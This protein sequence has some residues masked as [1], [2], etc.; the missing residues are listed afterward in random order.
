MEARVEH[1]ENEVAGLHTWLDKVDN[2][3]TGITEIRDL[4]KK[5]FGDSENVGD[6][7]NSQHASNSNEGDNEAENVVVESREKPNVEQRVVEEYEPTKHRKLELPIFSREDPMGWIFRVERYFSLNKIPEGEKME[8]VTVCLEGKALHWFQ[9]REMRKPWDGWENFKTELLKRYRSSQA[10]NGYE[11]LMAL[12]QNGDV[13]DYRQQ[14][15]VLSAPLKS[16]PNELLI[17]AFLNGL[18]GEIRAELKLGNTQDLDK[19]LEMAQKIEDKNNALKEIKETKGGSQPKLPFGCKWLSP[20]STLNKQV[21]WVDTKAASQSSTGEIKVLDKRTTSSAQSLTSSIPAKSTSS[22][23][24]TRTDSYRRLTEEEAAKR[25]EKGLGYRC[26]EKYTRGHLCKNKQLNVVLLCEDTE[27]TDEIGEDETHEEEVVHVTEDPSSSTLM[28]LSM[29]SI[30]GISKGKT[31]KLVGT[32]KE[33]EVL[34]LIDSG[35]SHNFIS[36]TSAARLG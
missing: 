36:S 16:A 31:M 27:E 21:G 12:K 10:R 20:T 5:K 6:G 34:I 24:A 2:A 25:R 23:A 26:D 35:A 7:S 9:W 19:V 32:V 14:F 22:T 15:V 4:L 11:V 33:Q 8:A 28:A 17:G 29:Q 3:L 18:K 1:L 30:V 13:E